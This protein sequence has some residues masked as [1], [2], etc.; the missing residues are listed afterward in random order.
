M[1]KRKL[2]WTPKLIQARIK[3]G[4]GQGVGLKYKP[5]L[6]IQDVPSIGHAHR[7]KGAKHGRVHHLLSNLE[8]NVFYLYEW[9][10][11]I[12]DIREQYPLLP[13]E[14]TLAIAEEIGVRHPIDILTKY[15]IV[16]TTDFFLTQRINLHQDY[17]A[18]TVKYL[19]DILKPRTCEKLEIE[20]RYWKHRNI[21][22]SVVTE[23]DIPQALLSNIKWVYP[24]YHLSDLHPLSAESVN[25]IRSVLAR[26]LIHS[27]DSLREVTSACDQQLELPTGRSLSVARHLLANRYWR[28]DMKKK[29]RTNE[30]LNLLND[31]RER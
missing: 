21:S 7:I 1:A 19:N 23:R 10:L 3:A 4:R 27:Q 31:P 26:R 17:K 8:A 18:R 29:I 15:P 11:Q 2:R 25:R 9:S 16:M 14:E 22:W 6:T 12:I 5:W 13:L 24:Y 28:V 30:K 20:R